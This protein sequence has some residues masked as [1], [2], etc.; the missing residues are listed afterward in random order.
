MV[1]VTPS[2]HLV[3]EGYAN[4]FHVSL[5]DAALI[6]CVNGWNSYAAKMIQYN[7]SC[8]IHA[9]NSSAEALLYQKAVLE[10]HSPEAREFGRFI[11]EVQKNLPEIP[12]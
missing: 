6:M 9:T 11:S 2:E 8:R 3:M 10:L 4:L 1:T 5:Q 7:K 12:E